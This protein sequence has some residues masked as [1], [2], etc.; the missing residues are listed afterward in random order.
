MNDL[1]Y[2]HLIDRK[3]IH[4]LK[5]NVTNPTIRQ[6]NNA[7]SSSLKVDALRQE[8]FDPVLL[9][10]QQGTEDPTHG[11]SDFFLAIM[12]KQQLDIYEKFPSRILCMD[13]THNTNIYSFKLI[14]LMVPDE[15]R[16][17][18]PVAFCVSNREDELPMSF[19]LS[20]ARSLSPETKVNVIM[21]DDDHAGWNAARSV[22][23][24]QLRIFSSH[25][26][27]KGHG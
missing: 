24:S 11:L 13:S 27:F 12:T 16:K 1:E 3:T 18:Y 5:T 23:W 14:K 10:K 8:S 22:Y 20:S 26:I 19:F 4:S 21:T 6:D 17:G 9:F 15:I 2:Y 25:G 7:L